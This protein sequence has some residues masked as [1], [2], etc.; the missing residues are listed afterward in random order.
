M[1]YLTLFVDKT[2]RI[3]IE[4]SFFAG[5]ETINYNG[6]LVSKKWSLFGSIHKF[7]VVENGSPVN[8]EIKIGLRLPLRIGFDI[9]RDNKPILLM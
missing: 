4:N 2:T 8:Y 7:N 9:Y 5:Y 3:D 1:R 6:E